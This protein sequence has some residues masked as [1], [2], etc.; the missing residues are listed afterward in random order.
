VLRVPFVAGA[1]LRTLATHEPPIERTLYWTGRCGDFDGDG[2][3]DLVVVDRH[4]PGVQILANGPDGLQ[5]ALAVPVFETR[6]SEQPDNEPRDLAVGDLDGDGRTDFVLIAHD[7]IL[8]YLQ[9]P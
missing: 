6:P 1:A 2:I 8:I 4:L 9:E 3:A 5:R 7:R